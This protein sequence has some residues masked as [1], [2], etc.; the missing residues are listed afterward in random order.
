METVFEGNRR[1]SISESAEISKKR[2]SPWESTPKSTLRQ[3]WSERLQFEGRLS[4]LELEQEMTPL[5][6]K[7]ATEEI[8]VIRMNT[9]K[10]HTQRIIPP[11]RPFLLN[12][13][14]IAFGL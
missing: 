1:M 3:D 6:D 13:I 2:D 10:T 5:V 14:P 12:G 7:A 4:R 11:V 9:A 8:G